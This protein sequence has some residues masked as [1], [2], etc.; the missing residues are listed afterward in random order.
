[1][2]ATFCSKL[3]F[4]ISPGLIDTAKCCFQPRSP[5]DP[6]MCT[7]TQTTPT[8]GRWV[9]WLVSVHCNEECVFSN[10]DDHTTGED[11]AEFS[12][13]FGTA[14]TSLIISSV[15]SLF[16]PESKGLAIPSF[17]T[18]TGQAGDL[19]GLEE[20]IQNRVID[21][22]SSKCNCCPFDKSALKDGYFTFGESVTYHGKVLGVAGQ[23]AISLVTM[24]KECIED[25]PLIQYQCNIYLAATFNA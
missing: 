14:A 6:T 21:D 2:G 25:N 23:P 9:A 7:P 20:D 11:R 15:S 16:N 1:M 8:I 4:N 12:L 10:A 5:V 3:N 24:L 18:C 13:D 22:I 19:R 17:N